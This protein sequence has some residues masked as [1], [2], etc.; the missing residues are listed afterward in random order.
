MPY[1]THEVSNS[2]TSD[3]KAFIND[4]AWIPLAIFR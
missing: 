1:H 2:A 4:V 3:Y